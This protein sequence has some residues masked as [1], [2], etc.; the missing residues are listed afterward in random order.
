MAPFQNTRLA[1]KRRWAEGEAAIAA[2]IKQQETV[3][4]ITKPLC[5]LCK[6]RHCHFETCPRLFYI[7]FRGLVTS[8]YFDTREPCIH[9]GEKDHA[10]SKCPD[11][12]AST[13]IVPRGYPRLNQS[14]NIRLPHLPQKATNR[15]A[16]SIPNLW[17]IN[18]ILLREAKTN[19][20][21]SLLL[22]AAV[23]PVPLIF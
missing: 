12:E 2:Q 7:H 15:K 21:R 14:Q 3:A 23:A 22:V 18:Q 16:A 11:H 20:R 8:G 5:G 1:C 19:P 13:E 10:P 6:E 9:C 4:T 17:S